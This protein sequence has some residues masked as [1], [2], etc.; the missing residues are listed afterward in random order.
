MK[1]LSSLHLGH[2][3]IQQ[4]LIAYRSALDLTEKHSL[5]DKVFMSLV[6]KVP[7]TRAE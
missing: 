5:W 3:H 7:G 6:K 4:S 2:W 1:K